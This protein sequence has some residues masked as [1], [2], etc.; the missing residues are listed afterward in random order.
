MKTNCSQCGKEMTSPPS[1]IKSARQGITCSMHCR[2]L[3][4]HA[5]HPSRSVDYHG[6]IS[7][8][9]ENGTRLEHRVITNAPSGT[10]VHHKDGDRTN[11]DPSNLEV[12]TRGE[13]MR[14]HIS[15]E[16][17]P[18]VRYSDEQ[19]REVRAYLAAGHSKSATAS[20]FHIAV[21]YVYAIANGKVRLEAL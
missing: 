3:R 18:L 1:R 2:D 17:H 8:M 7:V 14:L 5:V 12:M 13:H 21:S 20:K 9:T 10:V 15:G 19:I 11:N 4:K 6:Y 16:R